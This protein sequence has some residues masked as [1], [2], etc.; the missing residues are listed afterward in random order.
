[1]MRQ[2]DTTYEAHCAHYRGYGWRPLDFDT[3]LS[4]H[5]MKPRAELTDS[6]R[7]AHRNSTGEPNEPAQNQQ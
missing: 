1:M 4:W 7:A 2:V 3:W 6:D 5:L